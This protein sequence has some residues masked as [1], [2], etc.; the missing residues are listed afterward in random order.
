VTALAGR[1]AERAL[2]LRYPVRDVSLR[3]GARRERGTQPLALVAAAAGIGGPG[4][5]LEADGFASAAPEPREQ[6]RVD[7]AVGARLA[8]STGTRLFQGD[9]ALRLR[10][11]GAAVGARDLE[12]SAYD[13]VAPRVLPA[14]GTLSASLCATLGDVQFGFRAERLEDR[15]RP[16]VWIDPAT[17]APALGPGRE[18]VFELVWPLFD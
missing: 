2:W 1:T 14:H 5:R 6:P 15:R 4:L 9:L 7:P 17:G 10:I 11:E 8:L 18:L 3:V 16:Q 12:H 13:G